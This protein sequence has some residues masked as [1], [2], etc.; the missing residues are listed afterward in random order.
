LIFNKHFSVFILLISYLILSKNTIAQISVDDLPYKIPQDIVELRPRFHFA[1][2][3]QDTTNA[4]WSFST[5]SL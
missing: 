3:N 1:P 5:L 4:C 2:V